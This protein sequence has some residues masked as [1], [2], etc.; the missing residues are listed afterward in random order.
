ME[1]DTDSDFNSDQDELPS[2]FDMQW[3]TQ[4]KKNDIAS[5]EYSV[6]ALQR[7][8]ETNGLLS[9]YMVIVTGK[10]GP[11][12]FDIYGAN[13]GIR[14]GGG[15][16]SP[17]SGYNFVFERPHP[18]ETRARAFFGEMGLTENDGWSY[19]AEA[20]LLNEIITRRI[21]AERMSLA[22]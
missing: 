22:M 18:S 1:S 3:F 19:D 9:S 12:E 15:V 21:L 8:I 4:P 5:A 20:T 6:F 7:T 17:T 2:K 13:N 16:V 10:E 14:W 11:L